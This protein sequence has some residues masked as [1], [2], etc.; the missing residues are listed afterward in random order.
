M[1]KKLKKLLK[2]CLLIKPTQIIKVLTPLPL[3]LPLPLPKYA[4]I[5]NGDEPSPSK[6]FLSVDGL[7]KSEK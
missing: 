6:F 5:L 7:V 3:P 2:P 4:K 1:I